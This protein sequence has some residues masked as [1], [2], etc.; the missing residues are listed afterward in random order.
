MRPVSGIPCALPL[1]EAIEH[2]SRTFV[3]RDELCMPVSSDERSEIRAVPYVSDSVFAQTRWLMPATMG[4]CP[5]ESPDA[6]RASAVP[7]LGQAENNPSSDR[8]RDHNI[9][10]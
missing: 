4:V 9:R 3:P 7:Q 1:L 8:D 5:A 10:Q 6:T 2:N